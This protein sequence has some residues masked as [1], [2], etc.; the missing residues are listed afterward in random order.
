MAVGYTK[1]V[2]CLSEPT[3][4]DHTGKSGIREVRVERDDYFVCIKRQVR[5]LEH[6]QT[7]LTLDPASTLALLMELCGALAEIRKME[8]ADS[9]RRAENRRDA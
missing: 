2:Q 6:F 5:D 3:I 4:F 7:S 8:E 1:E 9:H